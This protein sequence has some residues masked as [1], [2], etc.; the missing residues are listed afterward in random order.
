MEKGTLTKTEKINNK[1]IKDINLINKAEILK[2]SPQN[3]SLCAEKLKN[4]EIVSFPTETVYG[5]GAN[6]FNQQ[7]VLNIF[8]FKGRPLSDP[9]ILHVDSISKIEKL[10]DIDSKTKKVLEKL[11]N[12]FWPGPL[13]I[14]LKA[15]FNYISKYITAN[16]DFVSFR[17]PKNETALSLLKLVDFPVA[18]PSANKFCHISPVTAEHVYSDFKEFEVTILDGGRCEFNMES[19]V[20]KPELL[21]DNKENSDIKKNRLVIYRKGAVSKNDLE[22][23]IAEENL[24]YTGTDTTNDPENI[25]KDFTVEYFQKSSHIKD[26]NTS[27]NNSTMINLDKTDIKDE[28]NYNNDTFESPG[29]FLKHYSP[30]IATYMVNEEFSFISIDSSI[31]NTNSNNLDASVTLQNKLASINSSN[32]IEKYFRKINSKHINCVILDYNGYLKNCFEKHFKGISLVNKSNKTNDNCNSNTSYPCVL[33]YRDL[34]E[35]VSE[36]VSLIKERD[37][38]VQESKIDDSSNNSLKNIYAFLRW[39]E[40]I[41]KAE[42]VFLPDIEK[43]I[44]DNSPDKATLSDRILKASSA[45]YIAFTKEEK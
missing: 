7:A 17:I 11:S 28:E 20:V 9:L 27:N 30:K 5:L 40:E 8:K 18:A 1:D 38:R 42:Y 26:N 4:G 23:F 45:C 37:L 33:A 41:D 22:D 6:C 29:Q 31:A 25:F 34:C 3:I 12:K 15:N 14:I 35:E 39:A 21:L 13:T 19:T 36:D 16:T 2:L 43:L 44:P 10:V 24:V 32:N